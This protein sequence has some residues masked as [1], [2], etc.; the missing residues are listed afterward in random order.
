[1]PPLS[2]MHWDTQMSGVQI[3]DHVASELEILWASFTNSTSFSFPEEIEQTQDGI[4]EGAVSHVSV[5]AYERNQEARR[6]CIEHYGVTCQICGFNFEK[7]YGE[8]GKD[9]I[10]V[11]HLKQISEI[12]ETY[13]IDPIQDLRPICPNCHAII[14]KRKPPYSIEEVKNIL[15]R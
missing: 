1:M 9:F 11:H 5:N 8:A 14:H 12:G 4:F 6:K 7:R 2:Q 15:R 3:P 13:Q 10:H